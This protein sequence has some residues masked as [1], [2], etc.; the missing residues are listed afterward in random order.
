MSNYLDSIPTEEEINFLINDDYSPRSFEIIRRL[1][2]SNDEYQIAMFFNNAIRKDINEA[3]DNFF[4]DAISY[5]MYVE[6]D[7]E[8]DW[9]LIVGLKKDDDELDENDIIF[10]PLDVCAMLNIDINSPLEPAL[11]I[12]NYYKFKD[13]IVEIFNEALL[14]ITAHEIGVV[15]DMLKKGYTDDQLFCLYLACNAGS[16]DLECAYLTS[17]PAS[18]RP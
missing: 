6:K 4:T 11:V 15:I 7:D 10:M 9:S 17:R 5:E 16:T 1:A 14:E 13:E 8:Y 3:L 12:E 2:E 18:P